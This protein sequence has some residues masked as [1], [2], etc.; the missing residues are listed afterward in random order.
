MKRTP[1]R[2]SNSGTK[3]GSFSNHEPK[4][5]ISRANN[6]NLDISED[7]SPRFLQSINVPKAGLVPRPQKVKELNKSQLLGALHDDPSNQVTDDTVK[8]AL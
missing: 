2:A 6:N 4:L 8:M 3:F 1:S 5:Q 7:L